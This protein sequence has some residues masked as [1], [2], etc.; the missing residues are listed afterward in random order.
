M[1]TGPSGSGFRL[2]AGESTIQTT[3]MR[4][5]GGII[6]VQVVKKVSA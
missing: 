4:M 5:P 3:G 2:P 6:N 1:G